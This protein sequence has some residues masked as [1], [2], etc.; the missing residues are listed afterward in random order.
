MSGSPRRMPFY[1]DL[2]L[3]REEEKREKRMASPNVYRRP[4]ICSVSW[5][6]LGDLGFCQGEVKLKSG[7]D[8]EIITIPTLVEVFSLRTYLIL[9][10]RLS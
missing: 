2:K 9:L 7:D 10:A 1:G 5:V 8:V 3:R 6:C 4:A